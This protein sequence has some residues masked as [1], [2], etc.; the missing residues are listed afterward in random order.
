MNM[1]KMLMMALAVA[2]SAQA[3]QVNVRGKITD[4]TGNGVA[5]AII[6]ITKL[7][8]KD[9]TG[10]DGTYSITGSVTALR[11]SA[12]PFADA[13]SFSRG[14]LE[15]TLAKPS[16]LIIE[17]FDAKGNLSH[18]EDYRTTSAGSYRLDLRGKLQSNHP[19]MVRASFGDEA[20]TFQYL[21][22][23]SY[24][25]EAGFS[26]NPSTPLSD[27]LAKVT[28]A[29]DSL[30]VTAS[31]FAAKSVALSTYDTTVNVTIVGAQGN[32][33]AGCGSVSPLKTGN[34]TESINGMNRKW[35]LDVPANYVADA[36][37]PYRLIFVWHPLGG[38]GS[39][40]VG[41]G[42]NGL[43]SLSGGTAIFATADGLQG[44]NSEANGT[45]WWNAN[46]GD[47][48]LV[49]AMLD[50]I[51]AGLCID[52]SRIFSTGFSF[53]GMMSY[54]LPFEFDVFRAVAPCS[55]KTGVIPYTEKFTN[56]VPIMAFH[57][58]ADNFV[59][60]NLGKAFF[61]KFAARNKCGT[62]TKAAS[63]NGCV[64]YQGCS[65]PSTW[66]L[67]KGG[68]TTWSEEPAAIWKFFSQF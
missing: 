12:K 34:F 68:H 59:L 29:I 21:P 4:G 65:M 15:L 31:G 47:M 61:D 53:G 66:C 49:Q 17:I 6:E 3:Q 2:W 40:V 60:T 19:S 24:E 35:M 54:T 48:K 11:G 16:R 51:N 8:L 9:T 36:N 56:P 42:Y 1:Q 5:N 41:S 10:A 38:S 28:A 62:Q 57:G 63:P 14:V 32:A 20:Q 52:P 39:Q 67:F 64:E 50:K 27:R 43:K 13:I 44:S 33:S 46:G 25:A 18:R 37:K 45:G 7:K 55:G 26:M 22:M 58:D 30:K 23:M